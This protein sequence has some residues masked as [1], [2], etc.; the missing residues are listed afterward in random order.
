[1]VFARGQHPAVIWREFESQYVVPM[2]QR[3][4]L[5]DPSGTATEAIKDTL[6][7]AP[8]DAGC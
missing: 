7:S 5:R 1:M 8:M 4:G 3:P 6:V 2:H